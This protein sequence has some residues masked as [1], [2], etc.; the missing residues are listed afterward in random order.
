MHGVYSMRVYMCMCLWV[1]EVFAVTYIRVEPSDCIRFGLQTL[2]QSL[3]VVSF[4]F[5]FVSKFKK[6]NTKIQ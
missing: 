6:K 1:P 3:I 4:H 2:E 5:R